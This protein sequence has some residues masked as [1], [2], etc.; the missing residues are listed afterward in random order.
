VGEFNQI[1]VEVEYKTLSVPRLKKLPIVNVE[2][3][4]ATTQDLPSLEVPASFDS[5]CDADLGPEQT[6]TELLQTGVITAA[7]IYQVQPPVLLS[8]ATGGLI[9]CSRAI[10]VRI[11]CPDNKTDLLTLLLAPGIPQRLFI[12]WRTMLRLDYLAPIRTHR[13]IDIPRPLGFSDH[14]IRSRLL[15]PPT[16]V[17]GQMHAISLQVQTPRAAGSYFNVSIVDVPD[18]DKQQLR[19]ELPVYQMAVVNPSRDQHNHRSPIY[20]RQCII[21]L[22]HMMTLNQ[23]QEVAS[24]NEITLLHSCI[25]VEKKKILDQT[26]L[27]D[28]AT[29]IAQYR[30]T[31]NCN[32]INGMVLLHDSTTG[33]VFMVPRSRVTP[34]SRPVEPPMQTQ[35]GLRVFREAPPGMTHAAKIDVSTAFNSV[36]LAAKLWPYFG[37]SMRDHVAH[38]T[39][40][41]VFKTL[42]QG[43]E[44]ASLCF[45][46]IMQFILSENTSSPEIAELIR[47]GDLYFGNHTDDFLILAKGAKT[48]QV[49]IDALVRLLRHYSFNVNTLKTVGP[50]TE[51]TFTGVYW[52]ADPRYPEIGGS[53]IPHPSRT[54][55]T[56]K[57]ADEA[58]NSFEDL[59]RREGRPKTRHALLK[60]FRTISGTFNYYRGWLHGGHAELLQVLY[61][62]CAAMERSESFTPDAETLLRIRDS[63]FV[64][65]DYILN[66]CPRMFTSNTLFEETIA[67]LVVTDANKR[68][69]SGIILAVLPLSAA[70]PR[71]E[72]LDL[73][74]F[75]P[76][77][78]AL[79]N[80]NQLSIPENFT[81]VPVQV[82]GGMWQNKVD[83]DSSSTRR[84]RL[85]QIKTIAQTLSYLC[86]PVVLVC[87]NSNSSYVVKD[88]ELQFG[89]ALY[90]HYE[91]FMRTV[92]HRIWIPRTGTPWV[93]DAVA[94]FFESQKIQEADLPELNA[95]SADVDDS[96][97]DS[98]DPRAVTDRA[99]ASELMEGYKS[100]STTLY[101]GT[102]LSDIYRFLSGL[103]PADT[104]RDSDALSSGDHGVSPSSLDDGPQ[105]LSAATLAADAHSNGSAGPATLSR[106]FLRNANDFVI[107]ANGL[108]YHVANRSEPRIYAPPIV[109]SLILPDSRM[110]P[111][112]N[113]L[114]ITSHTACGSHVGILSTKDVLRQRFWWPRWS[115]D[116]EAFCNACTICAKVKQTAKQNIGPLSSIA[117]SETKMFRLIFVDFCGPFTLTSG[118]TVHVPL[119]VEAC[120]KFLKTD[121]VDKLDTKTYLGLLDKHVLPDGYPS[122][123]HTDRG[124][125]LIAS[126]V[127]DW[128]RKFKVRLTFGLAY[129]HRTNGAAEN[130]IRWLRQNLE[131]FLLGNGIN[132]HG[133]IPDDVFESAL[134]S[135]TRQHNLRPH[136]RSGVSP[137]QYRYGQSP[138]DAINGLF[139]LSDDP[140]DTR[141]FR[142]IHDKAMQE[143]YEQA[144]LDYAAKY[145]RRS[146]I[147][148]GM[149]V[150]RKYQQDNSTTVST[151]PHTVLKQLGSNSWLISGVPDSRF[152][153]R[154]REVPTAQL[155]PVI[156]ADHL[157][158]DLPQPDWTRLLR[159]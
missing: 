56:Q 58:W 75:A 144:S 10:S 105:S 99:L 94:R 107:G 87:D 81:I 62:T 86:G 140:R 30:L 77:V 126:R 102:R 95:L 104:P 101:R 69:Y 96:L 139:E 115:E 38:R 24:E 37:T 116:V 100:D 135:A 129:Y 122:R 2:L 146:K 63:L 120:S 67:T 7:D 40:Y 19:I 60:W 33:T 93:A 39:R 54:P 158:A 36:L 89:G 143:S 21:L 32:N 55:L 57:F 106:K 68:S 44:L 98:S 109:T 134:N 125:Q 27:L 108:L 23:V 119:F 17:K 20:E 43:F 1:S 79:R 155:R 46:V 113:A 28:P 8:S 3:A 59:L 145:P 34:D 131:T 156:A 157:W 83:I 31:L 91:L 84:E 90:A 130:P 128:A 49:G 124:R 11:L 71:D 85:A 4:A 61:D 76:L 97:F 149:T 151:G 26:L 80:L 127:H 50:A 114:L 13:S 123:I 92:N 16:R 48:C 51:L 152:P 153:H 147:E 45:Y 52:R 41:F 64:I 148:I 53:I 117:A 18:S 5:G 12:G 14:A 150:F 136:S 103:L 65:A 66:G 9:T 121:I 159:N 6:A 88:A 132:P 141:N 111:L 110:A 78:P 112:R 154:T 137:F 138:V 142:E 35:S 118:R 82:V 42:V 22:E 73:P 29:V 133:R 70:S 25:K 74:E 15:G 72:L 47:T